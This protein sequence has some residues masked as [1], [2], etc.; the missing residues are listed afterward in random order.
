[1]ERKLLTLLAVSVVIASVSCSGPANAGLNRA[2]VEGLWI[3]NLEYIAPDSTRLIATG[4]DY[5]SASGD[6]ESI[7]MAIVVLDDVADQTRWSYVSSGTYSIVANEIQ[8]NVKSAKMTALPVVGF[9][10]LSDEDAADMVDSL[11]GPLGGNDFSFSV[12]VLRRGESAM[13]TQD[14]E[15]RIQRCHRSIK[16]KQ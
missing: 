2:D 13:T 4:H 15:D 6:Y 16:A 1:M 8:H 12:K 5:Y 9:A 7:G 14:D 11:V 10:D 3:C